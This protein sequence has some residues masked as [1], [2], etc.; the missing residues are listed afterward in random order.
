MSIEK[1]DSEQFATIKITGLMTYADQEKIQQV[2]MRAFKQQEKLCILVI[3]ENFQGWDNDP[4]WNDL[5]FQAVGDQ[6]IAKMAVVCAESWHN[7]ILMFLGDGFRSF[8]IQAF[9]ANEI[10]LAQAWLSE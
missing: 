7:E 3:F 9:Q 5:S 10:E 6:H 8:S 1:I 2:G 4:R